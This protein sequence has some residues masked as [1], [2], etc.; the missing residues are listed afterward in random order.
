MVALTQS[1]AGVEV[2]ECFSVGVTFKPR[3]VRSRGVSLKRD[4]KECSRQR[5]LRMQTLL[6]LQKR[7]LGPSRDMIYSR[8]P[9][10]KPKSPD[11]TQGSFLY[12]GLSVTVLVFVL[13][14]YGPRTNYSHLG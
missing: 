8:S 11:S 4:K 6:N 9:S 2:M 3:H 14:N 13:P 7:K 1:R 10:S 5:E 12:Y